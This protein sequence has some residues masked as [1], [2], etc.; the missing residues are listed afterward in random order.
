[1]Q[2]TRK[3]NGWLFLLGVNA[4]RFAHAS[5]L[6]R[7]SLDKF[8]SSVI[9][10]D[11]A[12]VGARDLPVSRNFDLCLDFP[13]RDEANPNHFFHEYFW[14]VAVYL[15]FCLRSRLQ[16][17]C[18]LSCTNPGSGIRTAL[19]EGLPEHPNLQAAFWFTLFIH[20]CDRMYIG[21]GI[22]KNIYRIRSTRI[23]RGLR[24]QGL[25]HIG[26]V[27]LLNALSSLLRKTFG[28]V[29]TIEAQAFCIYDRKDSHRRRLLNS[30][31]LARAMKHSNPT[32]TVR[33]YH[34]VPTSVPQAAK[35]FSSCRSFLAP[36]GA[37]AP[38]VLFMPEVSTV[39]TI[40]KSYDDPLKNFHVWDMPLSTEG[41]KVKLVT[42]TFYTGIEQVQCNVSCSQT[43]GDCFVAVNCLLKGLELRA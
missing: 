31:D 17:S 42:E 10:E 40:R 21:E 39:F 2:R 28:I 12:G 33:V 7:G 38:N 43:S 24:I 30:L 20:Y 8:C 3:W 35:L 34:A 29:P 32:I 22:T 37:W 1:M 11:S 16:L 5:V 15:H 27:Q 14:P 26:R 41:R 25:S 4:E 6:N 18:D 23:S 9:P 13:A 19:L 36:H